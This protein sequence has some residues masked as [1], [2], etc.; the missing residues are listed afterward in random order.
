MGCAIEHF[1]FGFSVACKD[2]RA[3]ST[4]KWGVLYQLYVAS[5][6]NGRV[7]YNTM[8]TD[9]GIMNF[10]SIPCSYVTKLKEQITIFQS[11]S[12]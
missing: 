7:Q 2:A 6:Q 3:F 8:Y 1:Y 5:K 10:T 11:I 12:Q 4:T 9:S